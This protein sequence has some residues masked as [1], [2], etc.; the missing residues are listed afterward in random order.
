MVFGGAHT[1]ANYQL[2]LKN[3]NVDFAVLG[4]GELTFAEIAKNF[5]NKK[6]LI[7]IKGIAIIDLNL[8][9]SFRRVLNLMSSSTD[10]IT[11]LYLFFSSHSSMTSYLKAIMYILKYRTQAVAWTGKP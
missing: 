2:I 7:S 11:R 3:K 1:S 9:Q 4:E 5:S 8:I 10:L 6:K